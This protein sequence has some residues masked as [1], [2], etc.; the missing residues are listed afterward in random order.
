MYSYGVTKWRCIMECGYCKKEFKK[1][2]AS[3]ECSLKCR[4]LKK[5][6]KE[7]ECWMWK[8]SNFGGGYGVLSHK[9]K[10]T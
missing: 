7:G 8:G 2:T 1:N 5:M 3:K 10:M 4:L 9:G 6:I